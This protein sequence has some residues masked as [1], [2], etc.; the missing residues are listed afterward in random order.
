MKKITFLGSLCALFLTVLIAELSSA[1]CLA[2]TLGQFPAGTITATACDGQ[3]S[4]IITIEGFAGEFSVINAV[5]GE[6]YVFQSSVPTDYFTITTDGGA[7]AVIHGLSP[8]TWVSTVTGEIILINTTN[9]ACGEESVDRTRSFICGIATTEQPDYVNLQFPASATIGA[10]ETVTVY[11][12]VYEGGL[13]DVV[14]NIDGQAPGIQA[15]VGTNADNTDPATWTDWTVA[16]HNAGSIGNNDEYQANIGA[17]LAPGTYYYATRFRL[18]DGTYV[19]GGIDASNNGNFWDGTTYMSGV[20]TVTLPADT[21]AGTYTASTERLET[22]AMYSWSNEVLDYAG[23]DTYNTTTVGA[24]YGAGGDPGTGATVAIVPVDAGYTFSR[25][26]NNLLV[27]TQSLGNYYTNEVRQSPAQYAVSTINTVTG[28]I[29]VEYSVFFSENTIERPFRSIYTPIP[30]SVAPNSSA[31]FSYYPNPV[32]NMLVIAAA[33]EI[34]N[35]KVYNILGQVVLTSVLNVQQGQIDMS[36]LS[37]GTYV[38][39]VSTDA[40]VKTIKIVKE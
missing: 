29:T 1:Q 34:T 21:L 12:Q 27:A 19:Y 13:T 35:V 40:E 30:L 4:N 22:G 32:K 8:L 9:A 36:S 20:L 15:W 31:T 5:A 37:K 16:T 38:V 23:V 39:K 3:T 26:G 6:T 24:Y 33:Q 10:G 17:S 25:V 11:G 28:V 18:N 2:P 7:T 14:P